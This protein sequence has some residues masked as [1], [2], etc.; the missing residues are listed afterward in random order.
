MTGFNQYLLSGLLHKATAPGWGGVSLTGQI[1]VSP[2]AASLTPFATDIYG[3]LVSAR[4]FVPDNLNDLDPRCL[5]VHQFRRFVDDGS[6]PMVCRAL[7]L[8]FKRID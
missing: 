5:S 4:L 3:T 1:C 6:Y 7:A 8:C 2:D